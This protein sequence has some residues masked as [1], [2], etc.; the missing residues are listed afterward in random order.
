VKEQRRRNDGEA[1]VGKARGESLTD[2]EPV[3]A[4]GETPDAAAGTAA[5]EGGRN[6]GMGGRSFSM[7]TDLGLA[8][9]YEGGE[10]RRG[11]RAIAAPGA[12]NA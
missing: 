8:Y 7:R 10:E 2:S 11:P 5:L 3:R 6:V 9:P 4:C 12:T 1:S